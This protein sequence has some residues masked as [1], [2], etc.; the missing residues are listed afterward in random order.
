MVLP[1]EPPHQ[2]AVRQA[3]L[4]RAAALPVGVGDHLAEV[5][6]GG[7]VFDERGQVGQQAIP[8]PL[9]G[10]GDLDQGLALERR[11]APGSASQAASASRPAGVMVYTVLRL[12]PVAPGRLAA[13]PAATSFFGSSYSREIARGQI[14]PR[15]RSICLASW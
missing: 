5:Q 9:V 6:L 3:F 10:V 1:Q 7:G 13:S 15:L 2:S 12:R 8:G 11:P 4:E 14:H